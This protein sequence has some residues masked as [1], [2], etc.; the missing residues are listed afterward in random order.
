MKA[1]EARRMR[2]SVRADAISS[3]HSARRRARFAWRDLE[4]GELIE[5]V[6]HGSEAYFAEL[7]ALGFVRLANEP[8]AAL[9]G[10]FGGRNGV[11]SRAALGLPRAATGS[12]PSDVTGTSSLRS[13]DGRR[14]FGV[15][16][17]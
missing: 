3:D 16:G 12:T 13:L 2:L 10:L 14:D 1:N 5:V 4:S 9:A 17:S 7:E 6:L 15:L 8:P 11:R